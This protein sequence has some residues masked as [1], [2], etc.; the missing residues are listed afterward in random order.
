MREPTDSERRDIA[1]KADKLKA[2]IVVGIYFILCGLAGHAYL[3]FTHNQA[4]VPFRQ[5]PLLWTL[6]L[7]MWALAIGI[8]LG[9]VIVLLRRLFPWLGKMLRIICGD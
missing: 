1:A 8:P 4:F 6:L 9:Y 7:V 5:A 3:Y 2:D